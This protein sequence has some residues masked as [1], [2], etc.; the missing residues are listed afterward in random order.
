[1]P[2]DADLDPPPPAERPEQPAAGQV[3]V[4]DDVM[5]QLVDHAIR[6]ARRTPRP[7]AEASA[8]PSEDDNA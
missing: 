2:A 5:D 8:A 7:A 1:V 4:A 6:T 3:H